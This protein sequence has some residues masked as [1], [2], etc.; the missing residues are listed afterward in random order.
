MSGQSTIEWTDGTWNIATGCTKV[1]PACDHCYIDRTMPFRVAHRKF[2]GP[3][4]GATTG[5]LLHPDRITMPLSKRAG[6]KWFTSS[7]T[8]VFHTDIPDD[9]LARVFAVMA[10]TPRHTYQVLT[11]RPARMAS[12]FTDDDWVREVGGE[13]A[14]LLADHPGKADL[15]AG[16]GDW[17][18]LRNVWCGVTAENQQWANIRIP[19]LL[20][21]PAARRFVS[22][23]PMLGPVELVSLRTRPSSPVMLD[24]LRGFEIAPGGS[25]RPVRRLDWVIAGGET[26][27]G[28]RPS[29]PAW[30]R[31]MQ[32]QCAATSTPFFFKQWGDW[33]PA[34]PGAEYATDKGRFLLVE[35]NGNTHSGADLMRQF[36]R[37]GLPGSTTRPTL[38]QRVGKKRAGR[39][40]YPG[41]TFDE[42]P[43]AV[44]TP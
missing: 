17:W 12:L 25:K 40:L 29:D 6:Q 9:Y 30:F 44:M 13:I 42:F 43:P 18:P 10:V 24:A 35:Q 31:L 34:A 39:D 36:A 7:L 8:D 32:I 27:P 2:D 38:M 4:T 1:S 37:G 41:K 22:V 5:V 16:V 23:E 28:A 15:P 20:E 3:D 26:G 11:K 21:T 19:I 14:A 33:A